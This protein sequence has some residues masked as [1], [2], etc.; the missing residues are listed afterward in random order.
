MD[1]KN[2]L[3]AVDL[4]ESSNI[5]IRKTISIAKITD[6]KVSFVFVDFPDKFNNTA[7][8]YDEFQFI[9]SEPDLSLAKKH[10]QQLQDLADQTDYQIENCFYLTG[11]IANKLQEEVKELNADLLVCGHHEHNFWS[12]FL[13]STPKIVSSSTTDLFIVQL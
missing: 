9:T 10:R 12:S 7:L 4:S 13:S 11:D 3:V 5:I 1:Y 2:I 8:S 6:A